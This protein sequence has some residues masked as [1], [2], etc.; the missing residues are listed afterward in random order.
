V[1]EVGVHNDDV[2]AGDELQAV[3]IGGTETEFAGARLEDYVW[4]AKGFLELFGAVERAVGGG[5][6]DDYDFVVDLSVR[7]LLVGGCGE[8]WFGGCI[9]L[10]EDIV[11]HLYQDRE[12][13]AFVVCW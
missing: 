12:V 10:L 13:L 7:G 8:S 11:E 9:L 6:V 2:R 4:G 1:G 3:N 5:V